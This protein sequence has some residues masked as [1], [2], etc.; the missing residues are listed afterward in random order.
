DPRGVL[1][2]SRTRARQ[3]GGGCLG[4]ALVVGDV[5]HDRGDVVVPAVG[6]GLRDEVLGRLV[7]VGQPAQGGADLVVGDL[8]GEAVAAQQQ[9]VAAVGEQ[10]EVVDLDV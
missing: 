4:P 6:A 9:A 10:L 3:R 1:A 5:D 7:R 8:V 2:R